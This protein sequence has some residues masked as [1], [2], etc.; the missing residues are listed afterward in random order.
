MQAPHFHS[1]QANLS[2][3]YAALHSKPDQDELPLEA[4]S[5]TRVYYKGCLTGQFFQISNQVWQWIQPHQTALSLENVL[6]LIITSLFDQAVH[7]AYGARQR[8]IWN[9]MRQIDQIWK[10]T[11]QP[12]DFAEQRDRYASYLAE[13]HEGSVE[14]DNPIYLVEFEERGRILLSAQEEKAIRH[15]IVNFHQATYVFWS[16]FIQDEEDN[17]FIRQPLMHLLKNVST[18][19]D[20]PLFKALEKEGSWVQMEGIMQ[21]AIPVDLLAKLKGEYSLTVAEN[22]HLKRWLHTLNQRQEF[23]SP[24]L[25][26]SILQEIMNVIQLQ[27]SSTLTLPD[28]L[29]WLDQQG[30]PLLFREDSPHLYW[31]EKL[32]PGDKIDCNGKEL[33]LGKQLSPPKL[34]NDRFK[35]FDLENYPDY[36]VKIANNRLLLLMEAQKASNEEEHW[37]VRL[38]ETIENLEE[39]EDSFTSGLDHQGRCIVLEKLSSPFSDIEWTSTEFKLTKEDERGALVLANHLYCMVQWKAAPQ[40]L[41]LSHLM[42]DKE[43]DLKSTRPLKKGA[44]NYNEWEA[45]CEKGAKG[46]PYVLNFL[47]Y[48]SQLNEHPVAVFYRE[49]VEHV[50]KTGKTNLIGRTLPLGHRQD[51]Y[52]QHIKKLCAQALELRENCLKIVVAQLRIKGEYSLK[53]EARLQQSA[54]DKLLKFYLS[55]PTPGRFA[56]DLEQQV[57]GSMDR[58]SIVIPL[59]LPDDV[60]DYYQEKIELMI[61]YN[62]A[63]SKE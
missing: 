52:N 23:I 16:L 49:A 60:E 37:G 57:I 4:A 17:A 27:G 1:L 35:I 6:Q 20:R 39:D 18:L 14:A 24:K 53:R 42:F 11:L 62:E 29:S 63:A 34:I 19:T 38:V 56:P 59:H 30:C 31:R 55:S 9:N 43:G 3:I 26:S 7:C 47:M 25:F 15:T 22:R 45:F 28:L 5:S 13:E 33:V 48:V 54:A 36:V 8:R 61:K 21:Q 44:A 51:F 40:N 12:K 32:S 46:N 2:E 10:D 58:S 41:S 50:L